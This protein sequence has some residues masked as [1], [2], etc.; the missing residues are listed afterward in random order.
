MNNKLGT[1]WMKTVPLCADRAKVLHG[2][3]EKL[4][5]M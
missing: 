3:A 5:K 1:D 2:N 4:L